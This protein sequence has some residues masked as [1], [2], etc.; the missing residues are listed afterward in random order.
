MEPYV[1][2]KSFTIHGGGMLRRVVIPARDLKEQDGMTFMHVSSVSTYMIALCCSA[3]HGRRPLSKTNVIEQLIDLRNVQTIANAPPVHD[4]L[5]SF[6]N[7]NSVKGRDRVKHKAVDEISAVATILSPTIGDAQGIEM[8]ILGFNARQG[9]NAKCAPLY[10]EL[11][12]ENIAY[13]RNACQWQIEHENIKRRKT[14]KKVVEPVDVDADSDGV[15][16]DVDVNDE[17]GESVDVDADVEEV[18]STQ[19][20]E[21]QPPEDRDGRCDRELATPVKSSEKSKITSFFRKKV[22]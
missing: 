14:E 11:D 17:V 19:Q 3:A 13:L 8:K 2:E 15:N 16:A 12:P 18:Y 10:V 22:T 4:E 20:T 7:A 1:I 6:K 5:R 9:F 21:S